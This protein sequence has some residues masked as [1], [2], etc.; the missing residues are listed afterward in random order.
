MSNFEFTTSYSVEGIDIDYRANLDNARFLSRFPKWSS[1]NTNYFSNAAKIVAPILEQQSSVL[2]NLFERI[3]LNTRGS[4]IGYREKLYYLILPNSTKIPDYVLTDKG[5]VKYIGEEATSYVGDWLASKATIV[6]TDNPVLKETITTVPAILFQEANLFVR[7][8][9][10]CIE[11]PVTLVLYGVDTK[12]RELTEIITL[13][14][15]EFYCTQNQYKAVTR[16]LCSETYELKTYLDTETDHSFN[17]TVGP[18]KRVTNINGDYFQPAF[19][20]DEQY[21]YIN[22][23]NNLSKP[24]VF[25]FELQREPD[26]LFITNLLDVIYLVGTDVYSSKLY[27]DYVNKKQYNSTYNNN[28]FIVIDAETPSVDDT[29]TVTINT[30]AIAALYGESQFRIKVLDSTESYVDAYGATAIENFWN[31]STNFGE[32]VYFTYDVEDNTDTTF[33]LE[34]YNQLQE[35]TC[36][37]YFNKLPEVKIATNA[38]DLFYKNH[39]LFIDTDKELQLHRRVCTSALRNGSL[40]LIFNE[41]FEE[42]LNV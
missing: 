35:Y 38:S 13:A 26:K 30:K 10:A 17:H 31:S 18:Q 4:E 8:A 32:K 6:D 15:S 42:I 2:G 1:A 14:S 28:D 3:T 7:N 37:Y 12:G 33:V 21:L 39:K 24:E 11:N 19:Y 9:D 25:K 41:N 27:L 5:P 34:I 22:N 20:L 36:G 23:S 29:V 16:V 40:V